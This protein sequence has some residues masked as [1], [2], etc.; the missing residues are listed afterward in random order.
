MNGSYKS[1]R[2]DFVAKHFCL[3]HTE[4]FVASFGKCQERPHT[5][6]KHGKYPQ[7]FI[8]VRSSKGENTEN[9]AQNIISRILCSKRVHLFVFF[10]CSTDGSLKES[11]PPQPRC[12]RVPPSTSTSWCPPVR[13]RAVMTRTT[14]VPKN[15]R[16]DAE[17]QGKRKQLGWVDPLCD[18]TQ[19]GW[20]DNSACPLL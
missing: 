18:R 11:A 2:I 6:V 19:A 3:S 16:K 14:G 1:V 4:I 13:T 20:R 5:H 12:H 10:F 7:W 15:P 9:L 8:W 17:C